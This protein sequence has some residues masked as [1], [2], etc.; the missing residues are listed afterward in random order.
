MI[1]ARPRGPLKNPRPSLLREVRLASGELAWPLAQANGILEVTFRER[2]K[3]GLSPDEAAQRETGGSLRRKQAQEAPVAGAYDPTFKVRMGNALGQL[4]RA[5]QGQASLTR[6]LNE[7]QSQLAEYEAALSA[8]SSSRDALEG[9]LRAAELEL[10]GLPPLSF[11][12]LRSERKRLNVATA[13]LAR[14]QEQWAKIERQY[15]GAS[16]RRDDAFA[17]QEKMTV[18]LQEIDA[19]LPDLTAKALPFAKWVKRGLAAEFLSGKL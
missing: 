9:E 14:L 19:S 4:E 13:R 16:A 12:A 5:L 6:R 7:G 15:Q 2:L 18:S 11:D 3:R 8:V 1:E 10:A 17:K